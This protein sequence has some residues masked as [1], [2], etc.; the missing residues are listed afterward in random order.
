F[1]SAL[2]C[3]V[4]GDAFAQQ[5]TRARHGKVRGLR[6]SDGRMGIE[7]DPDLQARS[8]SGRCLN[9]IVGLL[10]R[11]GQIGDRAGTAG[12]TRTTDLLIHSYGAAHSL[13]FSW[14]PAI[15]ARGLSS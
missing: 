4:R 3:A 7:F 8:P 15:S 9:R 10:G 12:W 1:L 6:A 11:V 13:A 2:R 5:R 14:F